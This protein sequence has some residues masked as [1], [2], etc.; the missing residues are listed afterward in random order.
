MLG[1]V[2][3][4][5]RMRVW[6][7]ALAFLAPL[8]LYA[9]TSAPTV[10]LEDS[11][12]FLTAA[13]WLGVPHP[14]G[15][16]LW[17]LFAH[18]FTWLPALSVA[19]R[20]HLSSAT[21]GAATV[22]T[23]YLVALCLTN[24]W[25]AA[26]VGA[27]TLAVSRV[28]WSQSVI[29]EVYS[30][31][32]F[33]TILLLYLALRWYQT[34]RV[35]WLYWLAFAVGL[36]LTNHQLIALVALPIFVWLVAT[37]FRA[38]LERRV[39]LGG[40]ALVVLGL[41][42][43]F[44]LPIRSA[45]SPPIDIGHTRSVSSVIEHFRRSVYYKPA[46]AGRSAGGPTDVVL[47]TGTAWLDTGRSIGWPFAIVALVGIGTW[48]RA[49]RS[50]LLVTLAIALCNTLL[51]NVI[52]TAPYKYLWIY[53]HRVYYIPTHVMAALWVA[54][55]A[56][57]VIGLAERRH[58]LVVHVT[59]AGLALLL[60]P[61]AV[62]SYPEAHQQGNFVARDLALDLLASAPKNAGFLPVGDDV[63]YPVLYARYVEGMRPDVSLLSTEYGWRHQPYSMLL[64]AQPLSDEMRRQLPALRDYVSIPRG[65]VYALMPPSHDLPTGY[66]SFVPLPSPPRDQGLAEAGDDVFADEVRARYATYHAR[67][68]ARSL[69]LGQR[70]EGFA[71]LDR[72][73]NLDPG[74]PHV[75]FLLFEIYRDLAIRTER[76]QPLLEKALANFD[77]TF[78][79]HSGRFD[80]LQRH[81]IEEE[82]ARSASV[83]KADHARSAS[84]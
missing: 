63:L 81:A 78:D 15:Y 57:F 7:G 48:P 67:L 66:Q 51:L 42:V 38:I 50:V 61:T 60:V 73:E 1:S 84:N 6:A 55:G 65:L 30:L 19:Q 28:L 32:A 74:D 36:G 58:Q 68:G 16:P 76:L 11:G 41:T 83:R 46:E 70:D 72:A 44:Y 52:L 25:R 2:G 75:E 82:L 79:P 8:A 20:V 71:E 14:P 53:V 59:F 33:F 29:A 69:A 27:L 43:Y 37:D 24:D 35:R 5:G 56:S 45:T 31:N 47:H 23:T 26:L 21:L 12:E 9:L 62:S 4:D 34:R 18:V 40:A 80:A 13:Y 77:R 17:C 64:S 54:S 39:V 22:L 10:T 49:Y 3:S